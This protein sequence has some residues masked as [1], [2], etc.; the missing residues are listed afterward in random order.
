MANWYEPTPE[1]VSDWTKWVTTC[2][3]Q[4][5]DLI[6]ARDFAFWKL[7]RLKRSGHRVTIFAFSEHLDNDKVTLKVSATG[8]FN[9]IA[10]DRIV[11]GIPP[12]ELEECELPGSDEL[13]GAEMTQEEAMDWMQTIYVSAKEDHDG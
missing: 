12:D 11:F 8:Q 3:S 1:Q 6:L 5:R 2:P 9:R 13:L 7:Y 4:I 10:F